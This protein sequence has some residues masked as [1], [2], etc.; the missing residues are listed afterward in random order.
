[1]TAATSGTADD[2]L[3]LI[4]RLQSFLS[5]DSN[6]LAVGQ[7]WEVLHY[8]GPQIDTE[9]YLRGR[10]LAGQ[11]NIFVGLRAYEDQNAD[12]FNI[13]C[14]PFLG[15]LSEA[16]SWSTQPGAGPER[17]VTAWD[18]AIP[19][20]I[21]ANGRRFILGYRVS[22]V[23]QILHCGLLTPYAT[24]L[25]YPLPLMV[26]GTM[27]GAL[28]LRWSSEDGD[29]RFFT[30]GGSSLLRPLRH[31]EGTWL[32]DLDAY[33]HSLNGVWRETYGAT[34][35]LMPIVFS[36]SAGPAVFG[37]VDGLFWISGFGQAS[38]N[39][40]S[41]DGEDYVV[42]QNVFRTGINDYLAMRLS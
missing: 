41:L 16:A 38:G 21:A 13:A 5:T 2:Y 26:A 4:D 22:T 33:P 27:T 42:L 8:D 29:H 30:H 10:G 6:L 19:Y 25:Q 24:P 32:T 31:V 23:D 39:T 28:S 20:W 14:R 40:F 35:P 12:L 37:E 34:Y 3:D 17:G 11:D 1:M 9:L 15:F 7:E 36:H 18:Q